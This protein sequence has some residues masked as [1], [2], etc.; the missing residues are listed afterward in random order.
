V[1]TVCFGWI[2]TKGQGL[3]QVNLLMRPLRYSGRREDRPM[4]AYRLYILDNASHFKASEV[5]E[6]E[7]APEAMRSAKG[8]LSGR[9]G[10]LWLADR[11]ICTFGSGS[12]GRVP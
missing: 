8:I 6:A 1:I 10:E 9:S 7:T 3:P 2:G 5:I 12:P 4:P 11:K